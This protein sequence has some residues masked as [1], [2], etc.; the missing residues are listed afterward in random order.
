M[1]GRKLN[2]KNRRTL[3]EIDISAPKRFILNWDNYRPS[4]S[5]RLPLENKKDLITGKKSNQRQM[6]KWT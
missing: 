2:L 4:Q 3:A 6:V 1:L 5:Y